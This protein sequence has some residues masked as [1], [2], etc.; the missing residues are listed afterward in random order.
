[1]EDQLKLRRNQRARSGC[2][3]R[4]ISPQ[5]RVNSISSLRNKSGLSVVGWEFQGGHYSQETGNHGCQY[6][7]EIRASP[8]K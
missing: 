5:A 1:M 6:A 4:V 7:P 3:E 8:V 2:L